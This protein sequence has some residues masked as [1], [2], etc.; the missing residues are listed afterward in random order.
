MERK[1]ETETVDLSDKMRVIELQRGQSM[2]QILADM[3]DA[4]MTIDEMARDLAVDDFTVRRW[5]K[6]F[7]ATKRYVLPPV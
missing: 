1:M 4:L 5:L 3:C 2:R 6:L 7:K